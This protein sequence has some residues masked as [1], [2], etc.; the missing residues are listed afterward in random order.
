MRRALAPGGVL[1]LA[2]LHLGGCGDGPASTYKALPELREHLAAFAVVPEAVDVEIAALAW[3][4]PTSACPHVVRL[5]ARYEPELMHE[6]DNDN[7]LAL[8]LVPDKPAP[9][10]EGA[11]PP[12]GETVTLRLFYQGFRAE[13]RG[14]A[15]DVFVSA[16]QIGPSAPTAAC[17]PR[18]WD[19]M[20]DALALAWP[21]LPARL[22]AVDEHWTGLRVEG[23][24][25]RSACVDP[26]TGGGGPDNHH[27]TCVTMS[28][29]ERLAGVF[30]IGDERFALVES[31][32][33][34][35]QP[36]GKGISAHRLALISIDH[37]RPVWARARIDHPFPQMTADKRQEPVVRT[38]TLE[39]IDACPGSLAAA[40]WARPDDVVAEHDRALGELADSDEVKRRED[41]SR[42]KAEAVEPD[43]FAPKP[44]QQ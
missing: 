22:A 37:G 40:G 44:Q 4:A 31:R 11:P 1:G 13:K 39:A 15:R 27:R 28:W 3:Q 42:R 2:L 38:W 9:A 43:P 24:C 19:P 8:G 18:T 10:F 5:H 23:R 6:S 26:S 14:T 21:R 25:N 30:D 34:D 12:V 7:T 35:G 17:T 36:E 32:W 16:E 29:D 20:E 41:A 33:S